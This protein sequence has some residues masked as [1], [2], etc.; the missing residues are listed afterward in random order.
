MTKKKAKTIKQPEI[1]Q[2][3]ATKHIK[4]D[5]KIIDYLAKEAGIVG[6]VVSAV[7]KDGN[8]NSYTMDLTYCAAAITF[9]YYRDETPEETSAR[10]AILDIEKQREIERKKVVDQEEYATFVRLSKKFVGR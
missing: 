10:L 5:K 2:V 7:I 9:E 8:Y 3:W 6:N 4:V 1:I